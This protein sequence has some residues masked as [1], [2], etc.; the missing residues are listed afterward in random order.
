MYIGFSTVNY[1]IVKIIHV[2][3]ILWFKIKYCVTNVTGEIKTWIGIWFGKHVF[4]VYFKYGVLWMSLLIFSLYMIA[5]D[6]GSWFNWYEPHDTNSSTNDVRMEFPR[7]K[8]CM[9]ITL[10]ANIFSGNSL[11]LTWFDYTI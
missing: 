8:I 10:I 1:I 11:I 5:L 7:K 9:K 3:K 2:Y 6:T 4:H